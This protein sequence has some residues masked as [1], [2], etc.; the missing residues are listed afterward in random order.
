MSFK[1]KIAQ[2]KNFIQRNA[3][4]GTDPANISVNESNNNDDIAILKEEKS[5]TWTSGVDKKFNTEVEYP[6]DIEGDV[7]ETEVKRGL[8]SRHVAM[9]ALGGTIGTGL[10]IGTSSP[11][12][13]AGPVN[14]LIA[15]LFFGTLA[16]SVTQSLGEMATHTP[17]AGSFCT[18]NERYLSKSIGFATNWL[19]WFQWGITFAIEIFS[20]SQCILY[21]TDR[22]P[23]WAW[24]LIF[25]VTITAANFVPVRY[26]GEIE[27]WIAFIK[28]VTIIGFLIYA[29]CMVCGAGKTGPV[30]FRYWRHPGPWGAGA[31]LVSNTNTD[32]FLGWVSSLINAAFTYQGVELTGISAGESANPRKT[33]PKAINK[34]IFRILLFYIL[35][36]FFCGLLVPYNDHRLTDD[37]SFISKSPF[38]IAI[39][40]SGTRV[41]PH[42]FNA[43]ILTTLISAANSNVYIGSRVLYSMAGSTAPKIFARVDRN[44]VPV[45]G[46]L[47]TAVFGA[48]AFLNVSNSGTT[49]FN[50]LMNISALAGLICWCF[51]TAAHIRFM[52]ILKSRNIS[53]D[54][55]P[56]KANFG[57][58]FAWI[59]E[60]FLVLIVFIQGYAVFFDFQVNDFFA[61]YISL[62]LIVVTWIIAQTTLYRKE[63]LLIPLDEIDID[64]ESRKIY[65]EVWDEDEDNSKTSFLDRFWDAII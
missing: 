33:V 59:T 43:V 56:F 28:I 23:V 31:G 18:F 1:R 2:T 11:L 38:L 62:M 24:I 47:F 63:P 41:L 8:K 5:T 17:V 12:H 20:A 39:T 44:G 22:V 32:R 30:G 52:E 19:Y 40:N 46:V 13:E 6:E 45:Y 14:T 53:R 15:Y 9:I 4:S 61:N 57:L 27:F 65:E 26:Y 25:F 48:L 36:L 51:I 55:L 58:T 7:T 34:V 54:T 21:W 37:G 3:D 60:F 16:Y 10:F 29:L 50:W 42:I 35:S 64:S 49:V